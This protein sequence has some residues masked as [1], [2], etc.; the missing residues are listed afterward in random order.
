MEQPVHRAT[1]ESTLVGK[2]A[3]GVVGTTMDGEP[4]DPG[5]PPRRVRHR[6][7]LRHLVQ[8]VQGRAPGAGGFSERHRET[9]DVR[10]SA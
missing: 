2:P 9:G 4:F 8:P 1:T 7:L 3:P 5:R 10:S 6:Q